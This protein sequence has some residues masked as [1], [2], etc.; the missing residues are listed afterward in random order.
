VWRSRGVNYVL[1]MWDRFPPSPS[2]LRNKLRTR[3]TL[4]HLTD[5]IKSGM[6][7]SLN[8]FANF[9]L[10]NRRNE[11]SYHLRK[12]KKEKKVAKIYTNENGQLSYRVQEQSEKIKVTYV[13]DTPNGIPRTLS[14]QDVN[15]IVGV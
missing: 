3:L 7:S 13:P 11:L 4:L 2:K 10:T 5:A 15:T 12:L 14:I 6:N 9:Q 8:L 1:M